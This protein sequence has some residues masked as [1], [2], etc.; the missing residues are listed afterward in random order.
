VDTLVVQLVPRN[1]A[2]VMFEAIRHCA[3]MIM[4]SIFDLKDQLNIVNE[5]C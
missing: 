3:Q 1:E 4:F 5:A 2:K